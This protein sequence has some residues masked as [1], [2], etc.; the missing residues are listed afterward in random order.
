MQLKTDNM[1]ELNVTK[2]SILYMAHNIPPSP[3]PPIEIIFS[4][5]KILYYSE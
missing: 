4:L 5:L 2:S 1:L 3:P